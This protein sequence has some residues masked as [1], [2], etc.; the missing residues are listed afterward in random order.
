M[1]GAMVHGDAWL[2]SIRARGAISTRARAMLASFVVLLAVAALPSAASAASLPLSVGISQPG[3]NAAGSTAPVGIYSTF[4]TTAGDQLKDVTIQLPP[5]L[6]VNEEVNGGACLSTPTPAPSCQIGSG[7]ITMLVGTT[8][9]NA[10]AQVYLVSA[11]GATDLAGITVVVDASAVSP[12]YAL[13]GT[14]SFH[15]SASIGI[16]PSFYVVQDVAFSDLPAT[17]PV[18]A[19]DLT[20]N[21]L[22]MPSSCQ[23]AVLTVTANS[24]KDPTAA[25]FNAPFTVTNC[26][27]LPFQ[28]SVT[29]ALSRNNGS[30]SGAFEVTIADPAGDSVLQGAKIRLPPNISINP[31]MDPCFEGLVCTVGTVAGISPIMPASQLAGTL[32]LGGTLR[33]PALTV[34]FPQPTSLQ[35]NAVLGTT[36]LTFVAL[37]EI[38]MTS[39]RLDFLGNSLGGMF[40]VQCY[41]TQF[42]GVFFPRSGINATTGAGNI[43]VGNCSPKKAP[44]RPGKPDA[45]VSA[46]G[47]ASGAPSLAIKAKYGRKAPMIRSLSIGLSSGLSLAA[48]QALSSHSVSVA[49]ASATTRLTN[50]RLIVTFKRPSQGGTVTIRSPLLVESAVLRHAAA[51]QAATF[52]IVAITITDIRGAQTKKTLAID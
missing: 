12:T 43:G 44:T 11:P 51:S 39:L 25:A 27:A 24:Q 8:L 48:A 35:L 3:G 30:T 5:G 26:L 9:T 33:G 15:S 32:I 31:A 18:T 6:L 34:S 49:G 4:G 2:V 36:S 13:P 40:S 1:A 46:T 16:D 10:Q 52:A 50:G 45:W 38:P 14:L 17:T 47:L 21:G 20:F 7:T 22:T 41:K 42:S 29:A 23:P 37:P 19:M 28:P